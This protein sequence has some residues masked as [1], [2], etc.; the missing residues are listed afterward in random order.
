[1]DPIVFQG[2]NAERAGRQ[3]RLQ[4]PEH[5]DRP[6]DAQPAHPGRLLARR[7][8]Q[9]QRDLR[10]S[11]SSTSWRMSSSRTRSSSAARC[12]SPSMS[13]CSRRWRSEAGWGKP[14]PAGR[15][16]R[17]R[18]V[19]GLWQLRRGLR[20]GLGRA[21]ATGSRSTASSRRPIRARPSTRRRSSGRSQARSSMASP[22]C[23]Y[24]E[25]TV[26]DGAIE[27]TN[28]DTYNVMRIDEMP[29]VETIV[30]PSGG[31]LGR[32]RRADHRGRGAGGAQRDLRGDR[33]AHPHVPAEEPRHPHR[34]VWKRAAAERPPLSLWG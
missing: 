31:L 2:L 12:S 33:Q 9:P 16:P 24:G 1:M 26:K 5:P 17:P 25:C 27:Q 30:M 32:R 8:R 21:T 19:H 20:R 4:H 7:E 15:V 13:P 11:A 22:R 3:L 14:A 34:L 18:P 28:F 29:K 23:I 6:R 10:R